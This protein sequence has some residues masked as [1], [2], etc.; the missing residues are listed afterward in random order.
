MFSSLSLHLC[1]KTH[2]FA[3]LYMSLCVCVCMYC[4]WFHV[5][6]CVHVC[7]HH[8]YMV[9]CIVMCLWAA[10]TSPTLLTG[11]AKRVH[12][13][14]NIYFSH[15]NQ[16][17][18]SKLPTFTL[19]VLKKFPTLPRHLLYMHVASE[20]LLNFSEILKA[21]WTEKIQLVSVHYTRTDRPDVAYNTERLCRSPHTA[22]ASHSHCSH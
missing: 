3:C 2:I 11:A 10:D 8:W 16:L 4:I 22:K 1:V 14:G 5:C 21:I 15:A 19:Y 13:H 17:Q 7:A 9:V 6:I 12:L 20:H 18:R